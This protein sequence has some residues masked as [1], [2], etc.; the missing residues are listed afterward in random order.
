MSEYELVKCDKC[1]FEAFKVDGPDMR[2]MQAPKGWGRTGNKWFLFGEKDIDKNYDL[3]PSC[4][5]L[6][7]KQ[8]S[9]FIRSG[10]G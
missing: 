7:L 9:D 6:W 3:C 10:G 8:K 2:T 5:K 4:Y 1:K